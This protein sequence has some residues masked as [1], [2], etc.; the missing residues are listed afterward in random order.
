MHDHVYVRGYDH[1]GS[2]R[3]ENDH[4]TGVHV[5]SSL[6]HL[7]E[8]LV[9]LVLVRGLGFHH[10]CVHLLNARGHVYVHDCD[11]DHRDDCRREDVHGHH[12]IQTPSLSLE[13]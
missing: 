5:C 10:G 7:E 9:E 13:V 2:Y 12:L 1:A 11:Y 6:L 8:V 4:H 3:C